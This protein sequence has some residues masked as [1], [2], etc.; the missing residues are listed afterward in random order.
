MNSTV[1]VLI[2]LGGMLNGPSVEEKSDEGFRVSDFPSCP[3]SP[4]QSSL[5]APLSCFSR[6]A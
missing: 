5:S 4:S 3:I 1:H 6:P 2:M